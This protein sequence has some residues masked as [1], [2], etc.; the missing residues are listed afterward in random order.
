[1]YDLKFSKKFKKDLKKINKNN[2]LAIKK[3]EYILNLLINNKPL[4]ETHKN[5]KLHGD[6]NNCHE[7]HVK[8][9]I[10]LIYKKNKQNLI[11][12]LLRIGS[13]TELFG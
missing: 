13:H 8:P 10:L 7:C 6:F 5:H 3:L 2:P 12:Y 11:I 1:M 4:K 9:D